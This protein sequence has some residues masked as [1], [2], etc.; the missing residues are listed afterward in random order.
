MVTIKDPL[1]LS[2]YVHHHHFL[3]KPKTI[4][5][6]DLVVPTGRTDEQLVEKTLN[7][8]DQCFPAHIRLISDL[9]INQLLTQLKLT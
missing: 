2:L 6:A 8:P 4:F 7:V 9:H 3:Q 5:K 1:F